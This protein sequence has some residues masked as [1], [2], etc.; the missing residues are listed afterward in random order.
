M[1]GPL[2]LLRHIP[3]RAFHFAILALATFIGTEMSLILYH[4][5]AFFPVE[6]AVAVAGLLL[7]GLALWPA[8]FVGVFVDTMVRNASV[9]VAVT[10][11]GAATLEAV[12]AYFFLGRLGFSKGFDRT[13]DVFAFIGVMC[14]VSLTVPLVLV[15]V[16]TLTDTLFPAPQSAWW[17]GHFFV[18]I[19]FVPFILQWLPL[20]P[21]HLKGR[22]IIELA[23][24]FLTLAFTCWIV[25]FETIHT[26]KAAEFVFLV[27]V[28]Y[29]WV[30][31]RYGIRW[32]SLAIAFAAVCAY[33]GTG[34]GLVGVLGDLPRG[35]M[36]LRREVILEMLGALILVLAVI[37]EERRRAMNVLREHVGKLENALER[38]S[39]HDR[40]KSEFIAIL[41]HELRNPLAPVV[42]HLEL[43]KSMGLSNPLKESVGVIEHSVNT[44]RRLLSD[45]LDVT[46][47]SQRT[48]TLRKSRID[49]RDVLARAL[50]SVATAMEEKSVIIESV[51]PQGPVDIA[52][53][54]TR[55]EQVV[56]NLLHNAIKYG[57]E[58]GNIRLSLSESAQ[59]ITIEVVDDGPGISEEAKA[60]IFDPFVRAT[61]G[62]GGIGVGLFLS[63]NFVELHG[64]QLKVRSL[65]EDEG[66]AFTVV[67]PASLKEAAALRATSVAGQESAS[68]ARRRVLVVDDLHEA[69]DSIAR[70]LGVAGHTTE[71]AFDGEE[72]LEKAKRFDPDVILLDIRMPGIDGYEVARRLRAGDTRAM[73]IA[74]TGFGQHSDKEKAKAAG[75]DHHLTK[76][77]DFRE[78]LALLRGSA[79]RGARR[80]ATS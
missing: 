17:A 54:A 3:V 65:G 14:L 16:G 60:R 48:V 63:K 59:E 25:Y 52:G 21:I 53:D 41:A 2:S 4:A 12:L 37:T 50:D 64:G 51:I 13:R 80:P 1:S 18:L 8:V 47:I 70:L 71:V 43:M 30:S 5:P 28:P 22:N 35:E 77:A 78:I 36:L 61:K 9:L 46:M 7:G 62:G 32:A 66:T 69:A 20:R 15:A 45:I 79:S 72:A 6:A 27:L 74:L 23:F 67:L 76:P 34:G 40:E 39:T 19:A 55:L 31:L 75:F 10:L 38:I 24:A 57:R 68:T 33:V 58:G 73:L 26:A 56:V 49:L 44:M 11:A 42:T 29:L